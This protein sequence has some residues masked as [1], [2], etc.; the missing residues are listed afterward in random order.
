M[1]IPRKKRVLRSILVFSLFHFS[2]SFA[3][4]PREESQKAVEKLLETQFFYKGRGMHISP[5]VIEN[6]DFIQKITK[7][8]GPVDSLLERRWGLQNF[9]GKTVGLFSITESPELRGE[10]PLRKSHAVGVL[11]CVACHSGKA[12]GFFIVGIGNKNI[13]T[14]QIGKDSKIVLNA[15][16]TLTDLT[17][18]KSKYDHLV[19]DGAIEFVKRL[20]TPELSNETQGLVATSVIRNWFYEQQNVKRPSEL[21]RAS[22]KVPHLFGYAEKRKVGQFA[23]GGGDGSLPGWAVAVELT[24]GQTPEN[25]REFREKIEETEHAIEKLAPPPYPFSIDLI[26]AER[27]K[28]I[29]ENNCMSC[30]GE[31]RS[32]IETPHYLP[33]RLISQKRVGTDFD[34]LLLIEEPFINFV[35]KN[36]LNDLLKPTENSGAQKYFA[37]RLHAIWARFPYL[38]NASV[39]T[40]SDLLSPEELRPKRFSL[41]EA[42]EFNR[43][44]QTKIGLTSVP[45]PSQQKRWIYETTKTG[46]SNQGHLFGTDLQEDEKRDLIEYLKSL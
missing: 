13:D 4:D 16:K 6:L 10:S 12:A 2:F 41:K 19:E 17:E 34:R 9:N 44:D 26:K 15:W 38:H 46:Q 35:R 8:D 37:P 40:L 28:T 45:L 5:G 22:V 39:P 29:F 31:H 24:A 36:P 20:S 25:V 43:F 11:G 21:P 3:A 32:S 18:R 14:G 23:D 42:G 7:D 33:P 30:H 27:G 1:T